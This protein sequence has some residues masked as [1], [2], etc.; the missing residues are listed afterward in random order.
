[1][2][3]LTIMSFFIFAI[4]G[5]QLV[6]GN[7]LLVGIPALVVSGMVPVLSSILSN[8]RT[9]SYNSD[10][11]WDDAAWDDPSWYDDDNRGS[12]DPGGCGCGCGDSC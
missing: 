3:F 8:R 4:S 10:D 12:C 7:Y 1:M 11:G 9:P 2:F 5:V 6:S